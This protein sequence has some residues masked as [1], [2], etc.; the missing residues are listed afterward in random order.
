MKLHCAYILQ[1]AAT[2]AAIPQSCPDYT[3]Y[4]QEKHTPYS[5]GVYQLSYQR[6]P[7]ECRTF[8]SPAVEDAITRLRNTISDPDLFRLFENAFPN[9]L[10]T[11]IKWKGNV[12]NVTDEKRTDE[13]LTF[14]ITGDM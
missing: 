11:A 10:D 13:E 14:I 7:T 2:A 8:V 5:S 6:P 9:T 1:A 4:S 3:T 12:E